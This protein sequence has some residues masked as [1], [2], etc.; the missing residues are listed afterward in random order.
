MREI[1]F[2]QPIFNK[3]GTYNSWHYWG[4]ISEGNFVSPLSMGH[5]IKNI[6]GLQFTGLKDKH[7]KEIYEGDIIKTGTIIARVYW[8]EEFARYEFLWKDK[9]DVNSW[10]PISN[11]VSLRWEIVGNIYED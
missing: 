2:R 6:R 8:R 9:G 10:M 11:E 5:N 7:G 3:D 4:W 1:K